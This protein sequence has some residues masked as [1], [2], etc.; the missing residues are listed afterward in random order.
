MFNQYMEMYIINIKP[1]ELSL[2]Q[3][4]H[5]HITIVI[6]QDHIRVEVIL[7]ISQ[8]EVEMCPVEMFKRWEFTVSSQVNECN[9]FSLGALGF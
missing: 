1:W 8:T 2:P 5:V 7:P 9:A 6:V 4:G 3:T